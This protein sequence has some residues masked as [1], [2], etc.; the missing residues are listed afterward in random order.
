M[1]HDQVAQLL[2]ATI[3]AKLP[4]LL[5]GAPG[6]G[7][8][9]GRGTP[10]LM[11]DGTIRAVETLRVGDTLMGPDSA[12]RRVA[13]LAHGTAPLYRVTPT[14]GDPYIVNDAHILSLVTSPRRPGEARKY[15]NISVIEYL[16][17]S[18]TFKHHAKGWRTS[19]EW[20]EDTSLPLEPYFLGVWLGDGARS[21]A[22]VTTME[23][24][25]V[26]YLE[27][28]AAKSGL[29][30]VDVTAKQSISKARDYNLSKGHAKRNPIVEALDASGLRERDAKHIPHRYLANSER[31]RL[32]LLA[33]LIDTDGYV[34]NGCIEITQKSDRLTADIL[35]LAR[36]LG[37]AAYSTR[38]T[39]GIAATGFTGE[40]NRVHISGDLERVPVKV[41]R[42]RVGPRKQSKDVLVTGI[43]V[44]PIGQGEYFG[45][46]LEKSDG[47]FLLGDFTVTH[48]TDI[49]LQAAQA[50]GADVIL[51][52]PAV[53]DP[54]DYKGLPWKL[55]G[56][57]TATFLPFGELK[58]ALEAD[59]P[60][61]FFADDLGQAPPSVQAALMQLILAR[62]VNGHRLSDHVVFIAATNRRE[63]RAGVSGLLE[64][65]KSRFACII[66][67]EADI[68]S[69]VNWANQNDI[70][71]LI[72]AFLM[73]KPD[74]LHAFEASADLTNTPSPRT[75]ARV[76]ALSKLDLPLDIQLEAYQGAV[77]KGAS[78]ELLAFMEIWASLPDVHQVLL[79]PDT[80]PVP[81]SPA[82]LYGICGALAAQVN[83]QTIGA[84]LRYTQRLPNEFAAFAVKSASQRQ[85][86]V[87][88]TPAYIQWITS[89]AGKEVFG[90]AAD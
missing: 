35:F 90:L 51:S 40:Y 14:K 43:R 64:P 31:V 65:V 13:S 84:M 38:C 49:V 66:E 19:V 7:K 59:R 72:V 57:D 48:N 28:F 21:G 76:D 11:H 63:D 71:P 27:A 70:N 16:R 82:G 41:A 30:L 50:A 42:R 36:S 2:A 44:E 67:L 46:T 83:Q 5:K 47:L 15:L 80:A 8:C 79:N 87:T 89:D 69:W 12:P 22:R 60:T 73:F 1:R 4:V 23:P 68:T 61:V 33:G 9:L 37:F 18:N 54:T 6:I 78:I 77:G 86:I 10:V 29:E 24:E 20:R 56:Q 62:E 58:K 81:D 75:W 3:P 55:E 26:D 17:K 34:T 25:V 53:S 88:K 32:E 74:L 39:K 85:S 45:F 52:H